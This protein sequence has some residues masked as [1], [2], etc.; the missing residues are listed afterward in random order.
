MNWVDVAILVIIG[1]F[2]WRG[3]TAGLLK[4][5]ARLAGIFLGIL[6]ALKYD[7]QLAD[8]AGSKWHLAE[9]LS[10]YFSFPSALWNDSMSWWSSRGL[11]FTG[12]EQIQNILSSRLLEII[13]FLLIFL[14]VCR[15]TYFV[16]SLLSRV[17]RI[18]FLGPV[19]RLGGL[20]LGL[21]NGLV[22]VLIIVALLLPLQIPVS[23]LNGGQPDNW[24]TR[25]IQGSIIIPKCQ[26]FLTPFE[27]KFIDLIPDNIMPSKKTI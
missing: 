27:G 3:L 18:A 21:V 9:K 15:L 8:F 16:G 1:W 10:K 24:Y 22:I 26:K 25:S 19:D 7:S 2:A 17:A 4:G 14:V 5:I 13:A 12:G 11:S 23:I 6:F 20:A